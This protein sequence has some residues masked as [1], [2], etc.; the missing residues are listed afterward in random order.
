MSIKLRLFWWYL[1]Y[2]YLAV[3]RYHFSPSIAWAMATACGDELFL[4]GES[5]SDSLEEEISCWTDDGDV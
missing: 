2:A 3:W 1:S 5:P 4:A